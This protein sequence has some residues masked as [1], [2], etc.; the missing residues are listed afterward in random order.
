M[1]KSRGR[2]DDNVCVLFT[3]SMTY[4][5][6]SKMSLDGLTRCTVWVEIADGGC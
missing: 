5:Y 4:A 6:N 3:T 2:M 1:K